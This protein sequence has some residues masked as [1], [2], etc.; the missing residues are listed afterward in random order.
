[1]DENGEARM[2]ES[3]AEAVREALRASEANAMLVGAAVAA[4][5]TFLIVDDP[6]SIIGAA[7]IG[8]VAGKWIWR[9]R[10]F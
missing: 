9:R 2:A 3:P 1:M 7:I 5:A 6:A 4:L 8:M 10:R